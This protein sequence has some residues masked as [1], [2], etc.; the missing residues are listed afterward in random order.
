MHILC[1]TDSNFVIPLGIMMLSVCENNK[2]QEITFHVI[3]D[4]SVTNSQKL[5]I[6][7]NIKQLA[8]V[9]FYTID[10]TT[11]REHLVVKIENFPISVYYRLLAENVLP[12]DIDKILYLDADI[13]VRH[14]LRE[15]WE[16]N[17]INH[18][19]GAVVNQ[20]DGLKFWE[21]LNYPVSKGYFNSGVIIINLKYF[22]KHEIGKALLNFII[23]NQ[24]ALM[25]PDQDALNFVLKDAKIH[26]PLR[27]NVQEGF[28]RVPPTITDSKELEEAVADPYILHYTKEK[29]WDS[30]CNHPLKNIYY[31]Y[32]Q[33]SIWK[34]SS[35]MEHFRHKKLKQ[36]LILRIKIIVARVFTFI[37]V[38]RN[39]TNIIYK[40]IAL[41]K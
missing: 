41:K 8:I 36:P 40:N 5:E 17:I 34:D 33:K 10:I 31:F 14:N 20:S 29:P 32:K 12:K 30:K 26:L 16:T 24:D 38:R 19:I 2:D 11:I 37:K 15:L 27:Y 22:R 23:N 21:R 7:E 9:K 6:A 13:I 18:A 1:C 25:M 39:K 35:F 4:D 3:I 28:Y